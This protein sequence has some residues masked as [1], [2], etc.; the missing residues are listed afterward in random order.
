MGSEAMHNAVPEPP[1]PVPICVEA[2][3]SVIG[4]VL[5]DGSLAGAVKRS[6]GIKLFADPLHARI[7]ECVMR[8]DQAQMLVSPITV[9]AA[10]AGDAGLGSIG[11]PAYLV[12][13]AGAASATQLSGHLALLADLA[14]K[15]RIMEAMGI[16]RAA[17]SAGE[18]NAARIAATLEASLVGID[19]TLGK[20]GPVSMLK[21]TSAAVEQV[22]AAYQGEPRHSVETGIVALDRILGGVHPGELILLGGRPGMGKSAVA[23]SIA[24]RI[25]RA[26]RHVAI[27]SLEMTPEALAMRAIAEATAETGTGAPYAAM[28]RGDL[29]EAQ[30]RSVVETAR[31]V[32]EL[33][34]T[35]LPTHYNDIGALMAGAQ[36][37][38][39]MVPNGLGL[40]VIDYAQLLRS[41][42]RNRY[43]QITEVSIALKALASRLNVPVLALSQLSRAVEQRDDKRPTLADL[44]ESG[45]L[46]QDA[47]V[48]IFAF[49]DEYYHE[50][51]RPAEDDLEA[52]REWQETARHLAHRLELIVAKHRQGEIG[53]AH[54]RFDAATNRIWEEGW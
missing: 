54:V 31:M 28:R 8:L 46:E 6:G 5:L 11:G 47:D 3:Q 35:F 30:M 22:S 9:G 37:I 32:G 40:L 48:V 50:R 18:E 51:D 38:H 42:A 26:G 25:A 15:R 16:A 12:R 29:S 34:I 49:R 14:A 13:L 44:R 4:S 33:P 52:M 1:D 41:D 45:Q 23:L 2:E 21:A 7:V 27:A 10:L 53:T 20:S 17:I 19:A 36:Q 39:R 24:T 43:E